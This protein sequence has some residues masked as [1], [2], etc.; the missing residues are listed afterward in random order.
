MANQYEIE[1]LRKTLIKMKANNPNCADCGIRNVSFVDVKIGCFICIN[2]AGHHRGHGTDYCRVKSITLDKF[3]K[4]EVDFM[5]QRGND[6]VNAE[7]EAHISTKSGID[8]KI[9]IKRK[10]VDKLFYRQVPQITAKQM[11]PQI[12]TQP[13]VMQSVPAAPITAID[14][15]NFDDE[16]TGAPP[17]EFDPREFDITDNKSIQI[18]KSYDDK[19]NDILQLFKPIYQ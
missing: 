12:D 4:A 3:S 13:T 14:L 9:F 11:I 15:L 2:C 18:T 5:S 7:Y 8:M 19:K 1:A 17:A 6:I 16:V 10:Y